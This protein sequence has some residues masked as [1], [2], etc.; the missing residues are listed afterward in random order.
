MVRLGWG[1]VLL[2]KPRRLIT[3]VGGREPSKTAVAV[4]R[5]L[6]ARHIAQAALTARRP[7]R[8]VLELDAWADGLH[9]ST[10]LAYA[11]V[12]DRG[13]RLGHVDAAVAGAFSLASS[14]LARTM[15][16]R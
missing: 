5:L 8:L 13:R 11:A 12:A 10:A 14:V 3:A 16:H 2:A 9:G 4:A 7:S 6:A 15:P 1:V